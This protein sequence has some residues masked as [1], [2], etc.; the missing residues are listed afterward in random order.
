[1]VNMLYVF[2]VVFGVV[3]ALIGAVITFLIMRNKSGELRFKLQS[4]DEDSEKLELK[5]QEAD[6][7]LKQLL[8]D[9]AKLESEL[10]SERKNIE[11]LQAQMSDTFEALSSKISKQNQSSFL[12]LAE[13]T[14]KRLQ[15]GAK[16]DQEQHGD[17]MKNMV[18]P[19][20]KHLEELQKVVKEV[21]KQ[22]HG[23]FSEL[24]NNISL[25]RGDHEKLRTATSSLV[26]ALRSP[27]ARGKWGEFHLKRALEAVGMTENVDFIQQGAVK[28][29]GANQRP[30][31]IIKLPGSR[32][33][34][35]DAKVPHEAFQEATKDGISENDR[36]H[37]LKRHADQVRKHMKDLGSKA[38]WATLDSPEFVL[39]YLP[40]EAY[41]AAALEVDST[42]FEAGIESKVFVMTPSTLMP[43]IS[44]IA[45]AWKQEALEQNSKKIAELGKDLY[46]RLCTFGGHFD[47]MR[48]GLTTA[49]DSYDKA[50]GSLERTVMPAARRFRDLQGVS[51]DD[52]L[53][54]MEQVGRNPRQLS[55][56]ESDT[57]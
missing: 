46:S 21:E 32:S 13:E 2:S 48:K 15:D 36:K 56:P 12:E 34:V 22:T 7:E 45:H 31:V 6:D 4:S 5:L 39:M 54:V 28:T 11:K 47:K 57:E 17:K 18:E 30:D 10:E 29:D 35:I 55:I 26:S 40:S 3:G 9:K 42:L 37:A 20:Q 19:V 52:K 1:M 23:S 38:Y 49:V 24:T 41:Y 27:T 33:I 8:Q 25:I 50:V 53:P 16:K 51:G 43:T 14:F 44:V